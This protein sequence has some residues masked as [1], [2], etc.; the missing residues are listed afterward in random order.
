MSITFLTQDNFVILGTR[1]KTMG[2]NIEGNVLVFF[3]MSGD[4]NCNQFEPV[5][6]K[7]SRQDQR[8]GFAIL[9]VTQNKNVVLWSRETSTPVVA[10]PMLILYVNGRPHAKFNGTKNTESI[11]NFITKA[12]QAAGGGGAAPQ[13]Q[14]MPGAGS[15]RQ[16]SAAAQRPPQGPSHGSG[17]HQAGKP[18]VPDI[19]K[20]PSMKGII[21][22][23]GRG[24]YAMGNNVEE[25]DEPKLMMP[26]NVIPHNS[27]WEGEI[28]DLQEH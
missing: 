9:D 7:L 19:G 12:L 8:I 11:Q 28:N 13:Q 23:A 20:A 16:A 18:W 27:P 24:G 15:V 2:I 17:Q 21:K 10:V 6:A 26:D 14:F 5:F 22:G 4:G 1:T 3:K 25:D